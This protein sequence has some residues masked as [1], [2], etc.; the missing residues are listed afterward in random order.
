[1]TTQLRKKAT[2]TTLRAFSFMLEGPARTV[3]DLSDFLIACDH[4]NANLF[5]S[6]LLDQQ[7][8]E[9]TG[10]RTIHN[11]SRSFV[12]DEFSPVKSLQPVV[13]HVTPDLRPVDLGHDQ[14]QAWPFLLGITS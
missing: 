3:Y 11:R 13:K 9:L 10:T 6:L 7:L 2:I 8:I 12:V 1:M 4:K 5:V 14:Q